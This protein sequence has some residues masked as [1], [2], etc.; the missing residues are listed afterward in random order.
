MIEHHL[1]IGL[2]HFNI[3]RYSFNFIR[4]RFFNLDA[5]I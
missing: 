3:I 2:F 5:D 1:K 4:Y